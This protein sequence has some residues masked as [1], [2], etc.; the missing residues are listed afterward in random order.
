MQPP[1]IAALAPYVPAV[2]S[3]RASQTEFHDA[4]TTGGVADTGGFCGDQAL[5]VDDI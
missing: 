1:I 3:L 5:V 4:V 2:R